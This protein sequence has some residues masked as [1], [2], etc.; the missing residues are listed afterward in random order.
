MDI[1]SEIRG[2][3][4]RQGRTQEDLAQEIGIA[5]Q[6]FTEKMQGRSDFKFG[7]VETI[8]DALR[9]PMSVLVARA[10]ERQR[11]LPAA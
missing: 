2:E 1:A 10:E 3:L 11:L 5:R 6:T 4:A 7:Q 9:V 8:A